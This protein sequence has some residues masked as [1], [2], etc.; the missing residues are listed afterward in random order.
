[1]FA[2]KARMQRVCEG[3]TQW[4]SFNSNNLVWIAVVVGGVLFTSL[5]MK[6]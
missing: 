4:L 3:S 6:L 1:M 2:S 5:L